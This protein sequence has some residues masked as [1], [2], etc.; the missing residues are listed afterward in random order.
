MLKEKDS[1][2]RKAMVGLDGAIVLLA[3]FLSYVL[4]QYF[5]LIYRL[6]LFPSISVVTRAVAPIEN[7]I[8]LVMFLAPLWCVMLYF[9][10]AYAAMRTRSGIDIAWSVIKASLLMAVAFSM[11]VFLF[12]FKFVSR[13][14]FLIFMGV[15]AL[16][17][18]IEKLLVFYLARLARKRGHNYRRLVI[19]GTGKRAGNFIAM[20]KKHA[21]WGFKIRGILDYDKQNIGK[22]IEGIRVM[23]AL[24]DLQNILRD[25]TT[26]EVVFLVPRSAL[27]KIE[28]S[29][30]IC[31]TLGV[32]ATI[33]IDFFELKLAR[34]RQTELGGVPLMSFETTVTDE[35]LLFIKRAVDI[36]VSGIGILILSPVFLITAMLI[37]LTSQGPVF[38]RQRRMGLNGRKF[39]LYKFRTM[40][41]GAHQRLSEVK[42]LNEMDGPVFK[43]KNDPRITP[44]G[45]FLRKFSIDELPQ[46][47]N[48]FIG[49]MSLVGPRP[50]IP[51]EV[52]QYEPWQRR[53]LSMRPGL[54]C[55]WQISGRNRI[56]F[57]QWMELDLEYIDTWSLKQDFFIL[58]KTVP[59]VLLG[60]GAS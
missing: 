3:F 59:V 41:K 53:R 7:Y 43:I 42:A 18:L 5:H 51:K 49:H 40:H 58:A 39:I 15:S 10:G 35:F 55:L 25:K 23:G 19:V 4:R 11:V 46:L 31:E 30:Y 56:D 37:K 12:K 26:D 14:F 20:I 32:K 21:E 13:A 45:R 47:F 33:A 6:D 22:D 44:V 48:V 9:S 2:I 17:I 52:A 38:F 50:P 8:I 54:T 16:F 57:K 60:V 28:H 27:D 29:L 36:I 1:V 24:D 34:L